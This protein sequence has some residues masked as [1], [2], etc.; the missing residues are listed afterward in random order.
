[1]PSVFQTIGPSVGL[2]ADGTN[3]RKGLRWM[4]TGTDDE[5][6]ALSALLAEIDNLVTVDSRP[7]LADALTLEQVAPEIWSG[8]LDYSAIP[9]TAGSNR[10]RAVGE[11]TFQF[12]GTGGSTLITHAY[13][14]TKYGASAPDYGNAINVTEEGVGGTEVTVPACAFSIRQRFDG[15]TITLAWLRTVT[16]L[17][18]SVNNGTFLGFEA[19]EVIFLGPA[20]SQ[21]IHYISG[22]SPTP[23][24]A[25]VEFKFAASPNLTNLTIGPVTG[26]NKPGHD[27]L[28][29]KYRPTKV[30]QALVQEPIGV[31]VAQISPRASFAGLGIADPTTNPPVWG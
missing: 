25:D 4:V 17:T 10:P 20:G 8:G 19:G 13:A 1:M 9:F 18:G 11:S 16:L 21:P 2:S 31:Y 28:W 26:I 24:P 23:G 29:V 14:Q 12:D 30:G 5:A 22:S 7:L 3:D 15:A 6:A 27:Y